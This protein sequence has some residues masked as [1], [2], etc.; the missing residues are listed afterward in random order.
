MQAIAPWTPQPMAQPAQAP[1][2]L[3]PGAARVQV[4][5]L[6]KL[7]SAG[8]AGVQ[9]QDLLK[10]QSPGTAEVQVQDLLEL[11]SSLETLKSRKQTLEH[12]L[13]Q[14]QEAKHQFEQEA[15]DANTRS[16]KAQRELA[17]IA[18]KTKKTES[19]AESSVNTARESIV[20]QHALVEKM[21]EDLEEGGKADAD[22]KAQLH[23]AWTE[24]AKWKETAADAQIDEAKVI[25]TFQAT[26]KQR[27]ESSEH[28]SEVAALASEAASAKESTSIIQE[29][30]LV[31]HMKNEDAA[32]A[33]A[34]EA[35][36][37]ASDYASE[38]T[39]MH[40]LAVT[41]PT[42]AEL[43]QLSAGQASL[44]RSAP[45]YLQQQ[46][47]YPQWPAQGQQTNEAPL[48]DQLVEPPRRHSGFLS[49]VVT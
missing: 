46:G 21:M 48:A 11:Q 41:G 40:G 45:P 33:H 20:K 4:Q 44:D 25:R 30:A 18:E 37:F 3:L 39:G 28:A 47:P 6:L 27:A 19:A 38:V 34:P 12:Q 15:A 43:S 10:L 24:R 17:I 2:L 13:E 35:A 5:D 23:E 26:L 29:D 32:A 42:P 7:Q 49:R 9:V 36:A 1:K 14:T 8:T 22:L 16:E 31:E